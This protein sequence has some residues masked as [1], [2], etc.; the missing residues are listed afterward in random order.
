MLLSRSA[1]TSFIRCCTSRCSSCKYDAEGVA[2]F[3][4]QFPSSVLQRRCI[5]TFFNNN[6][7]RV[8]RRCSLHH[9]FAADFLASLISHRTRHRV[10][11]KSG[12]CQLLLKL[13]FKKKPLTV[14]IFTPTPAARS[15]I[16]SN[17]SNTCHCA[18]LGCI[19]R[20]LS[21]FP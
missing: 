18:V 13:A 12:K 16:T 11:K 19:E 1:P 14:P 9:V 20:L 4:F 8:P 7:S 5:S 2:I 21:R 17:R 3:F 10:E 6:H 15:I